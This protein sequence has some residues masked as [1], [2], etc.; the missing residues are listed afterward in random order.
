MVTWIRSQDKKKIIN[1]CNHFEIDKHSCGDY[2]IYGN[3]H[4]LGLY[5]TEEKALKVLDNIQKH[6]TNINY[7]GEI[8]SD[9]DYEGTIATPNY[10]LFEMPQDS[11]I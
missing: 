4:L 11:T 2:A 10:E 6:I 1:C 3:Y 8:K 7:F 9:T 5:S